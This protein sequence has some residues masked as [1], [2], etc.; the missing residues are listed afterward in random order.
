[1]CVQEEVWERMKE[2]EKVMRKLHAETR[3]S[4]MDISTTRTKRPLSWNTLAVINNKCY[5]WLVH[6]IYRVVD[7]FIVPHVEEDP[8]QASRD[9][10]SWSFNEQI[11][12]SQLITGF[13][14]WIFIWH[15]DISLSMLWNTWKTGCVQNT[16]NYCSCSARQMRCVSSY[17]ALF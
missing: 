17:S 7:T 9:S 13:L 8:W 1:M 6:L 5:V 15:W 2:G 16:T 4:L 3:P 12:Q 10:W 11:R 14:T